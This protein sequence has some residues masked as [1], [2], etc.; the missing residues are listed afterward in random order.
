MRREREIT[1]G[2]RAVRST[3]VNVPLAA[4]A[5][6]NQAECGTDQESAG[7]PGEAGFMIDDRY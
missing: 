7:G 3:T 5:G 4:H 6:G 1:T 2:V